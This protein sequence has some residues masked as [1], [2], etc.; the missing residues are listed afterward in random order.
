MK[1]SPT[2]TPAE[3]AKFVAASHDSWVTIVEANK[4]KA[5]S[6]AAKRLTI[7]IPALN[8]QDKIADTI[9]GVL[10]LARELL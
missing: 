5:P 4:K 7:V 3:Y 9:E 10:P 2:S 8:E 1:I 6:R